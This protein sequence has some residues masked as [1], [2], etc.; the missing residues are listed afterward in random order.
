M[1]PITTARPTI[2]RTRP[3]PAEAALC[4]FG[5]VGRRGSAA[6]L[7]VGGERGGREQEKAEGRSRRLEGRGNLHHRGGE[8]G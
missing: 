8:S 3:P 2:V 5:P 4:G 7:P 6:C 1:T